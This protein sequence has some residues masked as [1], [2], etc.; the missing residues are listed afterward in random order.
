MKS[1]R[2][3]VSK[4]KRSGKWFARIT[5]TD[6]RGKRVNIRRTAESK[7]EASKLL[8]T[9]TT[10]IEKGTEEGLEMIKQ[11]KITFQELAE[12]YR[13]FKVKPAEYRG[14]RKIAGLRSLRTTEIRIKV[15]VAY[16]GNMKIRS[17]TVGE[18]ERFK[19]KRLHT[20]TKDDRERSITS[21]NRELETLR[22]ML[23]FARNEGWL[24][25]SPFERCSTPLIS[26][27][28]EKVRTR[29]LSREE[30]TKLLD[31]CNDP[32]RGHIKPLI[33]AALDTG[34]RKGELLSLSWGD[35]D[36]ENRTITIQAL[37]SKTLTSRILPISNRLYSALQELHCKFASR[38][39]VFGIGVKFQHSW[40][41]A[42]KKAEILDL[43]FHDLRATF[44][45]R[46]IE[47]GMPIE[48]VS[49]LSGHSQLSTL[50][51]HYLS[52]TNHTL[53]RAV[54]L[55]NQMNK[56]GGKDEHN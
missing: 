5:V 51:K 38:D 2:G 24:E 10:K 36:F 14:D 18:I 50:Y 48:Q 19:Q 40:E 54:E 31:A 56:E 1:D 13:K 52:N 32:V 27:A 11:E 53:D 9:L 16:F 4:D 44:C 46:L 8:K 3:Y 41:S 35:V 49:K 45:T 33:I 37:N 43:H 15:L 26:K 42:C 17:I 21:V 6:S 23:R 34:A 7:G 22:A 20:K 47:G 39:R 30:E 25:V 28:D 29:I 12:S 55:L